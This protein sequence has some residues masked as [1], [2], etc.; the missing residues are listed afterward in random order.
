MCVGNLRRIKYK[1]S[2]EQD[3][4][5]SSLDEESSDSSE[6]AKD[7]KPTDSSEQA[8]DVKPTASKLFKNPFHNKNKRSKPENPD[9]DSS[10]SSDSNGSSDTSD[11][12]SESH[13][14]SD[15]GSEDE[16]E[17]NQSDEEDSVIKAIKAAR[18]KGERKVPHDLKSED[19][20]TDI[21]FHPKNNLIAYCTI[22][23]QLYLHEYSNEANVLK[24]KSRIH[25]GSVRSLEFDTCG[26][27]LLSGGEDRSFQIIDMVEFNDLI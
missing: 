2:E 10:D 4:Q 9:K 3:T 1:M 19:H 24:K 12:D 15:E 17:N 21:S 26:K 13:D 22:E 7:V 6:Q 27:Y 16:I 20:I 18:E 14:D 5:Y 25:K 8:K 23:G 11:S